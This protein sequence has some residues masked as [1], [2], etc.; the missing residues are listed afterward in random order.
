MGYGLYLAQSGVRHDSAKPFKGVGSGVF[1]IIDRYDR[2]T[3]RT[4]Y[5]VSL[6]DAIYVLHAFEK[7][8][9]R[10]IATPKHTVDLVKRRL[11]IAKR[12]HADHTNGK[13]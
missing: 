2:N 3:Y 8:S 1:E 4:L 13:P 6:S 11:V 10:G 7:K 12:L 9:K 5:V